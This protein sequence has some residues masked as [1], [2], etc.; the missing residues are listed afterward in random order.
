MKDW[1]II[2]D[3]RIINTFFSLNCLFQNMVI[4]L[5][6]LVYNNIITYFGSLLSTKNRQAF[7]EMIEI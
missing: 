1:I 4:I 2:C 3:K 6:Y 7:F 5:T